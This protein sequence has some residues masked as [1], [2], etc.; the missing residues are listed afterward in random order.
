[1]LYQILVRKRR[2]DFDCRFARRPRP[3]DQRPRILTCAHGHLARR[4]VAG[5]PGAVVSRTGGAPGCD[6]L[7][8]VSDRRIRLG[9]T[10]SIQSL[11]APRRAASGPALVALAGPISNFLVAALF[12]VPVRLMSLFISPR[13]LTA[14]N[15]EGIL[16]LL[17]LYIVY[18]NLVLGVFNLIP[19]FPLD[20][21]SVLIG[22][23]PAELAYRYEQDRAAEVLAPVRPLVFPELYSS[24]RHHSLRTGG[25]HVAV[26]HRTRLMHPERPGI[27]SAVG[28]PGDRGGYGSPHRIGFAS[29][30]LAPHRS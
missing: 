30:V 23:L 8:H 28:S 21:F 18:F 5:T 7:A 25:N 17:L 29:A 11:C 9:Q 19:V 4:S 2:S 13:A 1:M 12:A 6:G 20:G 16:Y 27:N 22:V 14:T 10:G 3:G 24:G 15:P 26:A